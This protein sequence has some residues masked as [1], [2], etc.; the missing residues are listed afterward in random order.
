MLQIMVVALHKL[1]MDRCTVEGGKLGHSGG[2]MR[3]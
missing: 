3:S 1:F 2:K